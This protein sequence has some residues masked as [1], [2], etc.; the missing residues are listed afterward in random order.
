M[1]NTDCVAGAEHCDC[2]TFPVDDL[3]LITQPGKFEREPRYVVHFW[4]QALEGSCDFEPNDINGHP[5]SGFTV[6]STDRATFP[7]LGD[8]KTVKLYE[9]DQGFVNQA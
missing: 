3:G 5:V 1:A 9:D 2:A 7:E 6:R 8:T 4:Q